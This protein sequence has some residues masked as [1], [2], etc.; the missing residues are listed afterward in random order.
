MS[1]PTNIP[2]PTPSQ[3]SVLYFTDK[4]IGINIIV[5][6]KI[7]VGKTNMQIVFLFDKTEFIMYHPFNKAYGEISISPHTLH[8]TNF[9]AILLLPLWT[10]AHRIALE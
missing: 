1:N 4:M 3:S 8:Y 10:F 9:F 5:N 2:F 7:S 6:N